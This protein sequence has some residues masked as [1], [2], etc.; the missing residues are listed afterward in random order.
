MAF[1]GRQGDMEI[2]CTP[3]K[4]AGQLLCKAKKGEKEAVILGQVGK[5][6]IFKPQRR[7]GNLELLRELESYMVENVDTS[8]KS[9]FGQ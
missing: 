2:D 7:K 3:D 5:D 9:E 6:G 1:L 8:E 4:K